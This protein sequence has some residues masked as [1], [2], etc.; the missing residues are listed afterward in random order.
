MNKSIVI[1]VASNGVIGNNNSLVWKQKADLQHFRKITTNNTIIMGRKTYDSIGKPLPNRNN[2][3]ISRNK[4]LKLEGCLMASNI[5]EAFEI[6]NSL[7][8]DIFVIGGAEIY[9]IALPLIDVVYLTRVLANPV[10]DTHFDLKL[11]HNFELIQSEFK[12]K[13]SENEF[14]VYF[15]KLV[16]SKK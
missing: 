14:D 13:D 10:G 12:M 16:K 5:E 8:K 11:L 3:V 6:A 2:I 15:E 7:Q 9:N 4:N 1:A